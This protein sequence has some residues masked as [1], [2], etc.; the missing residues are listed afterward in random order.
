MI[1]VMLCYILYFVI[2]KIKIIEIKVCDF[3]FVKK[4]DYISFNISVCL[5]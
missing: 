2:I 1:Y 4:N 5:D 3:I